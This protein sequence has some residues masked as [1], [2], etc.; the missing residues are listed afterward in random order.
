MIKEMAD[1]AAECIKAPRRMSI[2]C[3][4]KGTYVCPGSDDLKVPNPPA[5]SVRRLAS[6]GIVSPATTEYGAISPQFKLVFLT[7]AIGTLLFVLLCLACSF[8]AG[9]NPPPLVDKVIMGFFDLAK[10]GFG[11]IVGLL[12][13]KAIHGEPESARRSRPRNGGG[14]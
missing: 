10:I 9:K 4:Q 8:L 7:A 2:W 13:G 6:P 3:D 5:P 1:I 12:G 14:R 11:A